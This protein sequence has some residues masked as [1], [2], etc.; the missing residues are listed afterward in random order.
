MKPSST[1]PDSKSLNAE[2]QRLLTELAFRARDGGLAVGKHVWVKIVPTAVLANQTCHLIVTLL[3]RH[4]EGAPGLARRRLM[5]E[6]HQTGGGHPLDVR[7]TDAE[8]QVVFRNV[9][10][11]AQ[12][13]LQLRTMDA[14]ALLD[15]LGSRLDTHESP[16]N[17]VESEA[18]GDAPSADWQIALAASSGKVGPDSL[19][20]SAESVHLEVPGFGRITGTLSPVFDGVRKLTLTAPNGPLRVAVHVRHKDGSRPLLGE[21]QLESMGETGPLAYSGELPGIPAANIG[22]GDVELEQLK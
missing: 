18:F 10:A 8:G 2:L 9:P 6:R 12:C 21:V 1:K 17:V 19:K 22:D 15:A 14:K 5:L 11:D 7:L 13:G 20:S 16:S 3:R 4:A